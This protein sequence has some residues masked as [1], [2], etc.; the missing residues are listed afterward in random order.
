M[1]PALLEIDIYNQRK[2]LA[3]YFSLTAKQFINFD[4]HNSENGTQLNDYNWQ[5]TS[6]SNQ[7]TATI[8]K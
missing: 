3:K 6:D 2:I 5:I 7:Q 1:R 8:P 4:L